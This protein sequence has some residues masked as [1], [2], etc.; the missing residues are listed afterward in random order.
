MKQIIV[1]LALSVAISVSFTA[2]AQEYPVKP[3]KI[4]VPFPPG[5][6][7]DILARI[8]ADKLQS[9]WGQSVLVD[10]RAGA[11]GNI[12]AEL[13][14]RAAPDGYTIL[15]ATQGQLVISKSLYAK[16]PFDPDEMEPIAVVAAGASVL[17]TSAEVPASNLQQLIAHARSNPDKLN[18]ASQGIG[19][20][21][22]LTAELFKSMSKIKLVHVPY[23]GSAPALADLQAGRVDM[24]FMELGGALPLI[25]AGKAR[26]LAVG[27]EKRSPVLP[28]VPAMGEFLPGF[29]TLN[30]TGMTAAPR[31]PEPIA[32]RI[33]AGVAWALK[34]PD[35][36]KRLVELRIEPIG[37]TPA[38]MAV[39]LRQERE[40]WGGVIRATGATAE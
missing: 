28:N 7:T 24:M 34:Q 12:G 4:I 33:S 19:S 5:G 16:L 40:R 36:A 39:F 38:E 27:S 23:K 31:T 22:H 2:R 1:G 32:S 30:W 29:I 13:V 20:S 21:A 11:N 25:Q 17:V 26:P 35:M 37:N 3:V 18:Y 15:F 14:T 8:V 9:R 6:G 10:N